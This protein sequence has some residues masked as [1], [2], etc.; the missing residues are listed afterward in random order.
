MATL[1][2]VGTEVLYQLRERTC[3][4]RDPQCD[5]R[6]DDPMVSSNHAEIV[7]DLSGA[8][9][10]RDLGS[11]R[12][13]FVGA[14]QI[15]EIEL[16]DGDE[17]LIGPTRMRFHSRPI[18]A[19][20]PAGSATGAIDEITRLRAIAG[21]SRA[22]G[23]EHDVRKVLNRV[24]DTCFQLLS[25]D[26]G[27]ITLLYP[28]SK[29]PQFTLAR[30]R[31][32]SESPFALSTTVVSV[33]METHEPHLSAE[34][35]ADAA[36]QRSASLS[37]NSVRSLMAAPLLYRADDVELLGVIQLDS[38]ADTS[39]F[40]PRDVEL[41]SVIAGQ[42]AL[43]IKNAMLVDQVRAA[44]EDEWRHLERVLR[45]LPAGVIV[46]D[47]RGRCRIANRWI[48]SR[49][50]LL[51]AIEHG[52][53]VAAI[54]GV[55]CEQLCSVDQR[56]QVSAQ[57]RALEITIQRSSDHGET[58]IVISD[59]T[60][61]LEQLTQAAHRDRLALVGQLAGGIAHDFN[62][63]LSIMLTYA[64]MLEESI[65]DPGMRADV[66][67]ITRA[68]NSAS[69]LT[70]QLLMFSRRE[71]VSPKVM[72]PAGRVRGLDS[73][74]RRLLGD[75]IELDIEIAG[76][77]PHLLI[78]GAQF[79]QI[80]V[81]LVINA[82]DAIVGRGRVRL[83]LSQCQLDDRSVGQLTAGCYA[84][85]EVEDTGSG[86]S[87]EVQAHIFEPYFTTKGQLQGSGLGL[88]TVHA[89]VGQ[90]HGDIVV[91]SEVD[92]GTT[93]RIFLP[94]TDRPL[95]ASASAAEPAPRD[96][97]TVLVVDDDD[98]VRRMVERALRRASYKVMTATSG[99]DALARARAYPGEIDLLLTDV[100]MPGMTGQELIRELS[101][102]R[103]GLQ[104][105]FMSGYHQGAPIDPRRFVAKPFDR[106][107]LLS[108][109]ADVLGNRNGHG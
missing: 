97:G 36:L 38:R 78:D 104:V 82:R 12:G 16:H 44:A 100:V 73:M 18:V 66:Q 88:A 53:A 47:R 10:L 3:I 5:I 107:T 84:L 28:G 2:E 92:C 87:P 52:A 91:N 56:V 63:L 65:T 99:P 81:N 24:L 27:A 85:L 83:R 94:E 45:D 62:N 11:R 29:N 50:R 90:A 6:L 57:G 9:R 105:V 74:L 72:D 15:E 95:E 21:L 101:A 93:F 70:R 49:E 80:V 26:R 58:V 77:V 96:G 55:P 8:Y 22:I 1:V 75:A 79:E 60:D 64:S 41:L 7:R 76:R 34:I 30:E 69:Q 59:N 25:A 108:T 14:H 19:G 68:A 54:A 32:G 43:A 4:G 71:I 35:D 40:L 98:D 39:V 46:L 17:L 13:T 20:T 33:V 42:A 61:E 23:V 86:M 89:I 102:E 106:A 67:T 103:P 109:V 31:N 37:V 48:T 51:G